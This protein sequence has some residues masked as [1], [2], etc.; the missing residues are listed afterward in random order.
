M[1]NCIAQ[2]LKRK[3]GPFGVLPGVSNRSADCLRRLNRHL[4][5]HLDFVLNKV[6]VDPRLPFPPL[7]F[8][9]AQ[10]AQIS[11]RTFKGTFHDLHFP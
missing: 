8:V 1:W 10:Y 6:E 9:A 4:R 5:N 3:F 7:F 2:R 11:A